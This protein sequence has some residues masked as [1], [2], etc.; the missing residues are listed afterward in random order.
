MPITE[1]TRKAGFQAEKPFRWSINRAVTELKITANKVRSGLRQLGIQPGADGKF[2]SKEIFTALNDLSPLERKAKEAVLQSKIDEAEYKRRLR[3]ESENRLVD[4]DVV[5]NRL[6]DLMVTFVSTIRH[7]SLPEAEKRQMIERIRA[8]IFKT[9]PSD[10]RAYKQQ[11]AA[12]QAKHRWREHEPEYE[13]Q[14]E[15]EQRARQQAS[16]NG[17]HATT[18]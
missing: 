17:Q 3:L 5:E 12:T 8:V 1:L 11:K 16:T 2:A 6:T 15:E 18:A 14:I 7:C 10:S 9:P 4:I 13:R